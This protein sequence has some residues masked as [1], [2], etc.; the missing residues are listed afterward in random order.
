[1]TPSPFDPG[2]LARLREVAEEAAGLGANIVAEGHARS[3][4]E[5]GGELKGVGDYVTDVDRRSESAIRTFLEEAT[6]DIPVLGEE[7]GGGHGETYWAVDPLDGTTNFLIG[8]PAVA[9]SVGLVSGRAC[10]AGAVRAPFLGLSFAGS[11]GGGAWSNGQ[12]LAVSVR[13]PDRAIVTTGPP[14]RAPALLP[15]YLPVLDAILHQAEDV[16][17]PG[18]ASLDLAWVAAGVFDG[19]FELNLSVWDLAAGSL[20]VQEAGGVVSDWEGADR[21]LEGNILAA[22]PATHELLLKAVSRGT[23]GR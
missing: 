11:R 5:T 12:R 20:L 18:A 19:Y 14:F 13:D 2:A 17:R 16:R 9:V 23:A 10:L 3:R 21:Y 15:R 1:M 6:P 22:S 7:G 8:F 4:P